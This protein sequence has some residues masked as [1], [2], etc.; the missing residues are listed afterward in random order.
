MWE[1]T[2][3]SHF[4]GP[5]R[6]GSKSQVLRGRGLGR[7]R[8]RLPVGRSGERRGGRAKPSS[9][10]PPPPVDPP[11]PPTGFSPLSGRYPPVV[12]SPGGRIG[13]T[14]GFRGPV[15]GPGGGGGTG[16]WEGWWPTGRPWV[17]H[18]GGGSFYSLGPSRGAYHRGNK[19]YGRGGSA[20]SFDQL[21]VPVGPYRIVPI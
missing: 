5:T 13:C 3:K 12:G 11:H 20:I 19:S 1:K 10:A 21:F 15:G 17:G 18:W 16:R 8:R 6:V 14:E 2:I 4:S 9:S 7:R